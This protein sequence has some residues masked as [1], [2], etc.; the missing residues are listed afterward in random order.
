MLPLFVVQAM[1]IYLACA[2]G[3]VLITQQAV[4]Q[5][6]SPWFV[7]RFGCLPV[8]NPLYGM[9]AGNLIN[10]VPCVETTTT[11]CWDRHLPAFAGMVFHSMVE[12]PTCCEDGLGCGCVICLCAA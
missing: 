5:V 7:L 1:Q 12:E 10:L 3:L 2:S 6:A 8:V 11:D 9:S 4:S